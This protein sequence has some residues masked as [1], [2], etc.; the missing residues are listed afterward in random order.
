MSNK[1][2]ARQNEEQGFGEISMKN[3]TGG[4]FLLGEAARNDHNSFD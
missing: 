3:V 2:T 4:A 1:L